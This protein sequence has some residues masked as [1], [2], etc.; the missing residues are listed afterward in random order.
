MFVSLWVSLP[1]RG[2]DLLPPESPGSGGQ[3][4]HQG[5]SMP[6]PIGSSQWQQAGGFNWVLHIL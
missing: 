3:G 1:S 4:H 6:T 5:D 2:S